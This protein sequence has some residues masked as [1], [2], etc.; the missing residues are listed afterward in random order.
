MNAIFS[1]GKNVLISGAA[2]GTSS[3]I[4]G[5][6]NPLSLAT[7]SCAKDVSFYMLV[8]GIDLIPGFGCIPRAVRLFDELYPKP[9][10]VKLW[11]AFD[12]TNSEPKEFME[13]LAKCVNSESTLYLNLIPY[14]SFVYIT[15]GLG[16]SLVASNIV[17]KKITGKYVSITEFLV[18]SS[19]VMVAGSIL[20]NIV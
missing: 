18:N 9:K 17:T 8:K 12:P 6:G 13:S 3:A 2:L 15:F 5:F 16:L 10:S 14:M 11:G 4:F 1:V 19:I 7:F 20:N